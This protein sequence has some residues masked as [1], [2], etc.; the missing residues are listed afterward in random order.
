[1]RERV[2]RGR[3]LMG[4]KHEDGTLKKFCD[5]DGVC[6]RAA[7]PD[8]ELLNIHSAIGLGFLSVSTKAKSFLVP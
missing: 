4:K 7:R 5:A 6:V 8:L 2:H 1:M 3:R